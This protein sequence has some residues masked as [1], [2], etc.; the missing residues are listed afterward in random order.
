MSKGFVRES[1]NPCVVPSLLTP[2]KDGSWHMCV[3]SCAINE[4]T[5][6]YQFPIPQLDEMLD[7]MGGST[8]F[9]KMDLKSGYHQVRIRP[10]DKWKTTFTTKDGIYEWM[11]ICHLAFP[12]HLVPS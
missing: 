12:M 1:L 2:K 11:V 6:R 10:E 5:I 8:I 3:D 7:V 9:S 4:I